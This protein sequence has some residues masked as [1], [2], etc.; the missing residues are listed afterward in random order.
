MKLGS[1]ILK[2]LN[3]KYPPSSTIDT[4]FHRYDLTFKTDADGNPI[5]LFIGKR[6]EKGYVVGE[7]FARTLK[8]DPEGKVLKDHWD[9]KGPCT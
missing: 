3:K 7:R 1:E 8:Y 4:E 2:V 5:Q 9:R 6:N